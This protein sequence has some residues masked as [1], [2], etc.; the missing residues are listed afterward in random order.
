[1]SI[2]KIKTLQGKITK[3]FKIYTSFQ[4][5]QGFDRNKKV[6]T[7]ISVYDEIHSH[8]DHKTLGSA[9]KDLER[10]LDMTDKQFRYESAK[11]KAEYTLSEKIAEREK[12]CDDIASLELIIRKIELKEDTP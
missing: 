10:F 11:E 1:M 12:L 3:K 8:R 2:S 4:C 6:Y 9:V 5:Q 7:K